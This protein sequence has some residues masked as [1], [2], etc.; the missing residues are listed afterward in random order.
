MSA[1]RTLQ[2]TA[3]RKLAAVVWTL[4]FGAGAF[5]GPAVS[6]LGT[7]AMTV[8]EL[9]L[10]EVAAEAEVIAIGTVAGE[11]Q[12]WDAEARLPFTHVTLSGIEVLKGE[13]DGGN[14]T[15]RLPG[16]LMP[17][18]IAVAVPGSPRVRTGE[19]LVV[20]VVGNDRG[21]WRLVGG[22]QGIYRV[23]REAERD[24]V[25][26]VM[27]AGRRLTLDALRRVVRKGALR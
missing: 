19:G 1:A 12:T 4:A 25:T 24:A 8:R 16:G 26:V 7:Q 27:R 18:G 14:L 5:G 11:D 10:S 6:A 21:A 13:V 3:R 15:L 22:P 2:P 17:G 9:T 23:V 20:F